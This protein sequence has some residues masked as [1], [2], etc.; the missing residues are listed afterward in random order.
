MLT[1]NA[2]AK[3]LLTCQPEASQ[4][5]KR[6]YLM[7]VLILFASVEGQTQKIAEFVAAEVERVGHET[8]V[9]DASDN[10][11]KVSFEDF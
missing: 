6:G 11:A 4:L 10:L 3:I 9:V 1:P 2:A 7:T 8:S 5:M